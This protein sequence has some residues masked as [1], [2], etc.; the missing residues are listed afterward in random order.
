MRPVRVGQAEYGDITLLSSALLDRFAARVGS[1][2]ESV[3][4]SGRAR[5]GPAPGNQAPVRSWPRKSRFPM[6]TPFDRS[7]S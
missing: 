6:A 3:E 1:G 7:R 2:T 4:G 5:G